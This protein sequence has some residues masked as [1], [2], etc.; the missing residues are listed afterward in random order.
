MSLRDELVLIALEWERRFCVAPSITSSI[1]EYDA[2]IL[3]GHSEQSYCEAITGRTA[4]TK[5]C[6]FKHNGLR[7]QIKSNRSSG[8]PGSFVTLV[9]KAANYDWDRLVWLLYDKGYV[10]QEAWEWSVE[11]YRRTFHDQA[12]LA[13][14]DMR[15]GKR[16]FPVEDGLYE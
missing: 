9:G 3:I 11:E 8:K 6:D 5:G 15:K 1:S 2:A 12:R 16:I 14:K 10:L 7:Y 13:P 4:V